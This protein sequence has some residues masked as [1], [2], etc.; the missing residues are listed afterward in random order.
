MN[1]IRFV[2]QDDFAHLFVTPQRQFNLGVVRPRHGLELV[3]VDDLEFVAELFALFDRAL[4][5]RHHSVDLGFP[6]V[7]GQQD[8]QSRKSLRLTVVRAM[9][10]VLHAL[11]CK[12]LASRTGVPEPT[13]YL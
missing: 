1:G 5:R 8:A 7:G 4:Q 11:L 3:V 6:R 2:V 9:A 10:Q 12:G 13:L